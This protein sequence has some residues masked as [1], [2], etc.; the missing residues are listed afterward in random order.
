MPLAFGKS[1]PLSFYIRFN[2]F[3]TAGVA[4]VVVERAAVVA[5]ATIATAIVTVVV[6]AA[7]TAFATTDVS[8]SSN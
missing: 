5:I 1:W 2:E 4:A 8:C 3:T 6:T 7:V